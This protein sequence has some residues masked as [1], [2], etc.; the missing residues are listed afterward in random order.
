MQIIQ[1]IWYPYEKKY[2]VSPDTV[3]YLKILISLRMPNS[4]IHR[5]GYTHPN[6]DIPASFQSYNIADNYSL[7]INKVSSGSIKP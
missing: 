3:Q 6:I 4:G 2:K 5:P 1:D 7:S